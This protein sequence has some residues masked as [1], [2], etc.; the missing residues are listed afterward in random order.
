M[1]GTAPQGPVEEGTCPLYCPLPKAGPGLQVY[2]GQSVPAQK[3][4]EVEASPR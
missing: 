4:M 3:G 2:V 1:Q